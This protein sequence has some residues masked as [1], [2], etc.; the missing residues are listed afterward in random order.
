M[1]AVWCISLFAVFF[2]IGYQIGMLLIR[3]KNKNKCFCSP[4]QRKF[5]DVIQKYG[6]VKKYR[7]TSF[8]D[9]ITIM[10][11]SPNGTIIEGADFPGIDFEK[12]INGR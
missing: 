11:G 2:F 12:V 6:T 3:N 1:L 7:G 10:E 9:S 8:L 4:E 5:L